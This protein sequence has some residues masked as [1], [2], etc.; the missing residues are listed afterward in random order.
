MSETVSAEKISKMVE[1]I[2]EKKLENY[3]SMSRPGFIIESGQEILGHPGT[4]EFCVTT[5]SLQGIHFYNQGNAKIGANK[6]IE[7]YAGDD[8]KNGA[9]DM[10]IVLEASNGS[11]KITAK[12]HDLILQG[13]NVK[14]HAEDT[15][16]L[17]GKRL[18]DIVSPTVQTL[19]T[20]IELIGIKTANLI[21]GE[22]DVYGETIVE[23]S[24]GVDNLLNTD[25]VTR[26]TNLADEIKKLLIFNI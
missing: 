1:E 24:E 20:N 14:I 2:V 3:F 5:D 11:V 8:N 12:S 17:K 25:I 9:K 26:L 4:G 21:G 22:V 6:S 13:N 15:I 10:A 7:I 19:S 16:Q 18:I 23:I